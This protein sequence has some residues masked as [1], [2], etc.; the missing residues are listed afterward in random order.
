MAEIQQQ[1]EE[2]KQAKEAVAEAQRKEREEAI[3]KEQEYKKLEREMAEALKKKYLEILNENQQI[4]DTR[5][6]N[7]IVKEKMDE[8]ITELQKKKSIAEKEVQDTVATEGGL[9]QRENASQD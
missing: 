2:R 9:T 1:L 7:D 6:S 3:Q 8:A 4:I 5:S